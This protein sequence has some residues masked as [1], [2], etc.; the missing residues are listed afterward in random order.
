MR[1]LS[2]MAYPKLTLSSET[3]DSQVRSIGKV[4]TEVQRK[5]TWQALSLHCVA[6]PAVTSLRVVE[7]RK[8]YMHLWNMISRVEDGKKYLYELF[9]QR[10][11]T[12]EELKTKNIHKYSK[13]GVPEECFDRCFSVDIWPENA[14]VKRWVSHRNHT[15][16]MCVA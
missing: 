5:T 10:V 11:C 6:G 2:N 3:T 9:P 4:W 13:I 16:E 8:Q 12:V 14:R 7:P 15:T 1:M